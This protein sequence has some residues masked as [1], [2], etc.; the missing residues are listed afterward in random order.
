[1]ERDVLAT[2]A[3]EFARLEIEWVV[4]GAVAANRYRRDVRLT[5]DIDLLLGGHGRGLEAMEEAFRRVGFE[6][7]RGV[8]N[9]SIVRMRH[10]TLGA[11][12]L[13][14]AETEYQHEAIR[15]ARRERGQAGDIPILRLEDVLVHKLIAGRARDLAD[16]ED[17]LATRPALDEPYVV[18]WATYWDVLPLWHRLRGA[19]R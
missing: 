12:D 4:M 2:L 16:I 7:R 1:M 13:V 10:P 19:A 6:V 15:R 9:G 11:V 14:L 8:P 3:A 18:R 17:I 5:G